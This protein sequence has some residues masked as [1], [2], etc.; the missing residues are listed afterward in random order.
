VGE[1]SNLKGSSAGH[2]Y[3]T[4]SD[5]S[6]SI[7]AALFAGSAYRNPLIKQLKNG[8]QVVVT[9]SVGVYTKRGTFQ[10]IVNRI[11]R[12]GQGDLSVQ[13]ERLKRELMEQGMFE[14]EHKKPI[15]PLVQKVAV[16]TSLQ[17]AALKDFIKVYERRSHW[18]DLLVVPA[19]VQGELAPFELM[20]ALERAISYHQEVAP[21]DVVVLTRG[22]GSLEDLNAFNHEALAHAI[23]NSPIP[24][25]SAVGHQ[26]D[27]TI[28]DFVADLRLETP[29]AAAEYLTNGQQEL[30][31]RL[32]GLQQGL[33]GNFNTFLHHQRQRLG[34]CHP[35]RI[36]DGIWQDHNQRALRLAKCDLGRSRV[37]T[38]RINLMQQQCDELFLRL[39][40]ATTRRVTALQQRLTNSWGILGALDPMTVLARG[41]S[42]VKSYED[43]I[44][45]DVEQF[46][47]LPAKRPISLLF[48]DGTGVVVKEDDR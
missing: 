35:S 5:K 13:F 31:D 34:H 16:I 14:Q 25:I 46:N 3:F 8:E 38:T 27:F 43:K 11:M 2:W 39:L 4:L 1:V 15:S 22:G 19:T 12:D 45:S 9:G 21:I 28:S 7:S 32:N 26:V 17:G 30:V 48:H 29:T 40:D 23:F 33:I 37:L 24:V 41:Y 20:H 47:R 10:V 42:I 36:L 44:V 6:S 18:M